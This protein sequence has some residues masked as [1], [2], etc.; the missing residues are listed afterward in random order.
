[1]KVELNHSNK[2]IMTRATPRDSV[3]GNSQTASERE[4]ARDATD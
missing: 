4:V 2:T 1:M 3:C